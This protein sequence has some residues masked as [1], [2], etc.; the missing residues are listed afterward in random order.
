MKKLALLGAVASLLCGAARA[1]T[2]VQIG[3][4]NHSQTANNTSTS[5]TVTGVN[6]KL[7]SFEVAA[8]STLSAA[9]W[10]FL[11]YDA[12]ADPGNGTV[13]PAKCF[14]VPSGTAQIGGTYASG[15]VT[16][17]NGIVG[18]VSTTGCGTETQS[19]HAY[20]AMDWIR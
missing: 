10:W 19:S 18:V 6:H 7:V 13:T 2:V 14:A 5:L 20:I 3:G 16:F 9:A 17:T 1:Q 4:A 12:A 11:I 15:G 8:D